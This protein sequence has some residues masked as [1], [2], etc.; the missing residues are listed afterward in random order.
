MKSYERIAEK[1]QSS[2][3]YTVL[4]NPNLNTGDYIPDFYCCEIRPKAI[5]NLVVDTPTRKNKV[6]HILNGDDVISLRIVKIHKTGTNSNFY[7]ADALEAYGFENE[8]VTV[9]E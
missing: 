5:G 3:P 6:L 2:P 4:D 7:N 1:D 9:D 8:E